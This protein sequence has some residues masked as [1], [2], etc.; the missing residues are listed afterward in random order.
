MDTDLVLGVAVTPTALELVMIRGRRA[1]GPVLDRDLIDID[2]SYAGHA[3]RAAADKASDA[4]LRTYAT[5]TKH[6]YRI[7]AVGV[8]C[9]GT[10]TVDAVRL[11]ESLI[12]AG[13]RRVIAVDPET[14]SDAYAASVA[15]ARAIDMAPAPSNSRPV[16]GGR[17]RHSAGSSH[18]LRPWVFGAAAAALLTALAFAAGMAVDF[19][20]TGPPPPTSPPSTTAPAAAITVA[21]STTAST[22]SS[23]ANGVAAES[24]NPT[25]VPPTTAAVT[26]SAPA[27]Q[28]STLPAE[29]TA[30]PADQN[31]SSA[32]PESEPPPPVAHLPGSD[33]G[34]RPPGPG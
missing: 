13:L 10:D 3:S 30:I 27:F 2:P 24:L 26:P 4:V 12:Q 6:G 25:T 18:R 22:P 21:R 1:E 34:P 16:D 33:D 9:V 29:P 20:S 7:Q 11:V 31:G 17:P 5:A 32:Q 15:A 28:D 8:T 14:A 23:G 19:T